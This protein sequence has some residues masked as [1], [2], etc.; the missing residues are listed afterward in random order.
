MMDPSEIGAKAKLSA[1]LCATK[2]ERIATKYM[3]MNIAPNMYER[4]PPEKPFLTKC[5]E[6]IQHSKPENNIDVAI[7]PAIRPT[8]E[9]Q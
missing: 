8:I 5:V 3:R 1:T 7:P 9:I 6:T 4:S 2:P